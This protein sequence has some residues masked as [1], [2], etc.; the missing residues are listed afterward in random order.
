MGIGIELSAIVVLVLLNGFFAMAE[1]AVVS[2]RRARLKH[3]AEEGSRVHKLVLK[4][5]E[6]PTRFLSTIQIAI[7]LTGALSGTLGGA[8]IAD[9]LAV[10]FSG[11]PALAPYAAALA[12][13]TVVL[14]ITMLSVLF[15]ELIPK[16]IALVH[17]EGIATA[18]I[19][20]VRVISSL[21]YPFVVLFSAIT[22][23]VLRLLGLRDKRGPSVTEE[24]I[25]IMMQ[26]GAAEGVFQESERDM[27]QSILEMGS[28]RISTYMTHRVDVVGIEDGTPVPQVI[29]IIVRHPQY[30]QFPVYRGGL[31]KVVGVIIAK[32]A[33]IEWQTRKDLRM[34]SLL[35]KPVYLPETMES[36]RALQVI[37]NAPARLAFVLDEYGGVEGIVTLA[38]LTDAVFGV[39]A[40]RVGSP[41]QPRIQ[42]QE[43]GAWLVDGAVPIDDFYDTLGV[44][45]ETAGSFQT[46]AGLLLELCGCIPVPGQVVAWRDFRLVVQ[47]MDG[48]RIDRVLVRHQ[49]PVTDRSAAAVE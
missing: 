14:L 31:D 9:S 15:G 17:P 13:A 24:E 18:V 12:I 6:Q 2:S 20:P 1:M 23:L 3:R 16:R 26:Q 49:G 47:Q 30:S 10:V 27:V 25:H 5:A 4:T 29:D 36:L 32:Q 40:W 19:V 7:T 45:A 44:R 34:R 43:N 33:L 21:F 8:T 11:V 22:D 41:D 35:T 37:R 38:D 42:R 48:R 28:Q 46:V 39:I